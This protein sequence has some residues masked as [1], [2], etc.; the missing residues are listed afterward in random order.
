MKA[1]AKKEEQ[2]KKQLESCTF[3]PS[4][5]SSN[6]PTEK[7]D[8]DSVISDTNFMSLKSVDK[9]IAKQRAIREEKEEIKKKAEHAPGSGNLI[10]K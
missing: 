2:E 1:K 4:L 9:Y 8:Y 5:C 3:K 10:Y 7:D 6:V